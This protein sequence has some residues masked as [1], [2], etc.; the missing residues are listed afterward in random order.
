MD[1]VMTV[2]YPIPSTRP[3]PVAKRQINKYGLCTCAHKNMQT[4]NPIT[5]I[6]FGL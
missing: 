1:K 4:D 2:T 5:P 3:K 6:P